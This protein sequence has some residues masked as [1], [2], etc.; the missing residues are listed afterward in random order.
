M[1]LHPA[2]VVMIVLAAVLA[3]GR[4]RADEADPHAAA[5]TILASRCVECHGADLQESHLRLDSRAGLLQGGDFGPAIVVGTSATSELVRRLRSAKPSE[6]MPPDGPRLT[7]E[8]IAAIAAWI[9]A[10]AAWP[11]EDGPA[12]IARDE[13]LDHWAWQPI[14]THPPPRSV[15]AFAALPGVEADRNAIDC[16]IRDTLS[17]RGLAPSPAADRRTLIRRLAFDLLGLPP[18]P[19]EIEAFVADPDPAA[20]EAL[21]DRMLASPRYGERWARH[22]LDVVHYGDTHGYDKDQPR[23]NAWPYRDYVIRSLNHDKPYA[24]FVAE[25]LAG[26]VLWPDSRDG[27]EALGFLAAGPWD[28]IGHAEVPETKT[29]GKIARHLDRDD[30]VANTIGTFASVTVHCAQCHAHKFDPVSQEDYYSLQSVFAAIDRDD[31]PYAAD[32]EVARRHAAV[33]V[34]LDTLAAERRSLDRK[35]HDAAGPRLEELDRLI[36]AAPQATDPNPTPAYGWHAGIAARDDVEKWV[37]VDLGADLPV[38]EVV[39]HP[40]FDAFAGIGGGFGYPRR[41][42]I[43]IANDPEF[44]AGVTV[45]AAFA[46]EDVPNPGTVPQAFTCGTGGRYVRVTA[47]KLA[48]RQNDFIVALAELVVRGDDGSNL[49]AGKPVTAIDSIE[50]APRWGR[51]NL[52]DGT[53]PASFRDEAAPLREEREAL[54]AQAIDPETAAALDRVAADTAAAEAERATL[55]PLERVYAAT[56]HKRKGM[57]RP[58]HVLSRGNVLAPTYEVAPGTLSAVGMLVPRFDL[59][60]GHAEGERRAAL[61]RWLV[62]PANPLTWRS[63]VNRVWQYHFGRGLVDTPS[64]FGRMG[65]A[66]SHPEL[67]DWLAATFRDGGGSLKSLHRLIVTSAT[68]RQSAV[69]R[70]EAAAVD[71]GNTL[72]WRQNR[73]RLEAEAVRDAV[74]AV[75]GGLDLTM[76]GPG[77]QD[78]KVERPEH[79]PH[80]RYDLADPADRGT[81]RRGVYRFIVRSQTQPFMTSLDCADPSMRVEKRNESIS[82][83]QALALLNNGFMLVQAETFAARV[84]REAG[85]EPAAQVARAF[86]LACG[87][88][89]EP[90]EAAALLAVATEHGMANVCRMLFN[91]NEFTFV[92]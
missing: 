69:S 71:S 78:F 32:P 64:D 22:W 8:E 85:P 11:G 80:Y 62:D 33:A 60:A 76:G 39:L 55:P 91:L 86:V 31:R 82:A 36:A 37:Q 65:A 40:C 57:P 56:T 42:R 25:Q 43:E 9:D 3:T 19:E 73:R 58:I 35:V 89:A 41:F 45:V 53:S 4:V 83:P 67:L 1:R 34:R 48:P 16:F 20:Y 26:D 63:A 47:T 54:R 23:P 17:A 88:P 21:V 68:Y 28:L 50:A 92:D 24:R 44:R 49:A 2:T 14:G 10:G 6:M 79:S 87:R 59:P 12:E 61:A 5:R 7:A 70:D 38:R 18:E 66:P 46:D 75:S 30:M 15:T 77:W 13:R 84:A 29:D 27:Q 72:L 74:L 52:V 51:T 81:W 90:E